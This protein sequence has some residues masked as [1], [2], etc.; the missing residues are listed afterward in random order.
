VRGAYHASS[1]V[2]AEA[3]LTALARELDRTH[4][5]AA[6]LPRGRCLRPARPVSPT[7]PP[8]AQGNGHAAEPAAPGGT[9]GPCGRPV[10][11]AGAGA[12]A[13]GAAGGGVGALI[14]GGPARTASSGGVAITA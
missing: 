12:G 3:L 7:H 8:N 9:L 5:G 10:G 13:A 11:S 2:E 6:I 1:A 4:P 14:V